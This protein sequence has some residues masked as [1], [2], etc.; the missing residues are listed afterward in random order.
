LKWTTGITLALAVALASEAEASSASLRGSPAAMAEQ[1]RVARDHGL[2]FY[3]TEGEIRAA[4][5]RGD[6]VELPGNDDYAVADFVRWPYLHPDAALFVER[7]ASQYREACGQRL[8]VTSGV[9]PSSRQP[10]NSHQLS[11]HPAGMAVDLRVSD[12]ATC[13]SWL[14]MAIL[15][16]ERR[17]L[18]NGIR[19][20]RPPHYH[21]AVYPEQYM[22]HVAPLIAEETRVAA[23]EAAAL[24]EA[25][26]R[27]AAAAEAMAEAE[28]VAAAAAASAGTGSKAPLFATVAIL[29]VLPLGRVLRDRR[30]GVERRGTTRAAGGRRRS[31]GQTRAMRG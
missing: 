10:S 9:R 5:A 14:E 19:E 29:L 15:N 28:R 17:G 3:R 21:V 24:A 30:G 4:V 1:N 13:R 31:D 25:E 16:L 7:L 20:F 2:P 12:R 27:A 6:L 8:V 23:A 26:A 18:I 22:A 11:V